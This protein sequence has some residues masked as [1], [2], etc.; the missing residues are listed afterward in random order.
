MLFISK[1][2][3]AQMLSGTVQDKDNNPVADATV[4]LEPLDKDLSH[5]KMKSNT[6]GSVFIGQIKRGKYFTKVSKEGYALYHLDIDIQDKKKKTLWKFNG[7]ILSDKDLPTIVFKRGDHAKCLFTLAKA[8][9]IEKEFQLTELSS[10]DTLISQGKQE[11]A[12]TKLESYSQSIL[13]DAEVYTFYGYLLNKLNDFDQA[14]TFLEKALALNPDQPDA[15][16]FLGTTYA[17]KGMADKA[18]AEIQKELDTAQDD[19]IRNKCY[20]YLGVLN[21]ELGNKEEAIANFKKALEINPEDVD[22]Y[23]DL[24]SLHMEDKNLDAAEEIIAKLEE[25]G[26]E[27]ATFY[28][29]MAAEFWNKKDMDHSIQYFRKTIEIDPNFPLAYKNLGLALLSIGKT[30]ESKKN[31][32]HYLE[33][34][35][36]PNEAADIRSILQAME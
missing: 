31:L 14:Q 20:L 30:E 22:S 25:M 21:R 11:E 9:E 7:K 5:L 23:M 8:E 10:V 32:E 2:A 28:Y 13:E 15:H 36:D 24:L 26:G 18:L 34:D 19:H 35:L 33:F 16:F 12:K 27:D 3:T 4:I 1:A 29:N 6:K 17:E